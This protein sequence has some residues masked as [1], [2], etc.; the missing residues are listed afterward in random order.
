MQ[1]KHWMLA[2]LFK[3]CWEE[4]TNP[5]IS[6]MQIFPICCLCL[7]KTWRFCT[8]PWT[9]LR[10]GKAAKG[11]LA[12]FCSLCTGILFSTWN[13][14]GPAQFLFI[15]LHLPAQ[16]SFHTQALSGSTRAGPNRASP[17]VLFPA[18]LSRCR[19][20]P[21]C[22]QCLGHT[23]HTKTLEQCVQYQ[24]W[25]GPCLLWRHHKQL[26]H[27]L[28]SKKSW[29]EIWQLLWEPFNSAPSPFT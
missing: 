28:L 22:S 2:K 18:G 8:T 24:L 27:I 4:D 9:H 21:R 29:K 17:M 26:R 11:I 14:A 3:Y 23:A 7:G 16:K 1:Q 13:T 25:Q 5:E 19:D 15:L 12:Q 6:F 20:S 10:L